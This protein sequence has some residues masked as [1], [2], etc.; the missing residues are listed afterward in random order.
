M[1]GETSWGAGSFLLH[2]A[3]WDPRFW[4][5]KQSQAYHSAFL[6]S[7]AIFMMYRRV[8]W[9]VGQLQ[10]CSSNSRWQAFSVSSHTT[11]LLVYAFVLVSL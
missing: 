9:P 4:V 5:T 3:S 8:G 2:R 7:I 1:C 11:L 10:Y 6:S